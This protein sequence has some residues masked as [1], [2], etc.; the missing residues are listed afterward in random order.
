MHSRTNHLQ[1]YQYV[2]RLKNLSEVNL[3]CV[4]YLK[5]KKKLQNNLFQHTRLIHHYPYLLN[6]HEKA[7]K[8]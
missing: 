7:K 8:R 2:L 5:K 6:L 1:P 3:K 4:E